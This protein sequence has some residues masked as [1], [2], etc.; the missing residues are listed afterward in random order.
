MS[1]RDEDVIKGVKRE[2]ERERESL[3][4]HASKKSIA[5]MLNSNSEIFIRILPRIS[6][7]VIDRNKIPFEKKLC[8]QNNKKLGRICMKFGLS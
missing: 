6:Y 3:V 5:G 1:Y 7:C 8:S 4:S 2:R